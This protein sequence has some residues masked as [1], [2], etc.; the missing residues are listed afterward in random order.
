M[1]LGGGGG[2]VGVVGW[3][4]MLWQSVAFVYPET[5]CHLV[6][7]MPSVTNRRR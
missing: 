3:T 1:Y 4:K 7:P 6:P 5:V 2:G